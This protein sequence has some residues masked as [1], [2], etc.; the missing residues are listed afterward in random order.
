MESPLNHFRFA[1]FQFTLKAL[2]CI[3][4]PTYK[5]STFRGVFGHA[6][7]KIVCVHPVRKFR[8][9]SNLGKTIQ[10]SDPAVGHS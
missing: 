6:F 4:L 7:K 8:E 9:A 2:D 1:Q 5:G 3:N 10:K